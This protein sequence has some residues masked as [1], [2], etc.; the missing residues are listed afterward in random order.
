MDRP[1]CRVT[2]SSRLHAPDFAAL[3]TAWPSP[4]RA[5]WLRFVAALEESGFT[6]PRA[7][8]LAF[9]RVVM[10][11]DPRPEMPPDLDLLVKPRNN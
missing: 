5:D 4:Y 8:E 11:R 1:L 2:R 9:R 7:E 3:V 6:R 10:L